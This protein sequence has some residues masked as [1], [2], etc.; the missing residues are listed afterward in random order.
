MTVTDI[1]I[2][3]EKKDRSES[4]GDL[5][6]TMSK[7][8]AKVEIGGYDWRMRLQTGL[9]GKE[10]QDVVLQL[11]QY[12][13]PAPFYV[14]TSF[15]IDTGRHDSQR[16][17]LCAHNGWQIRARDF[18]PTGTTFGRITCQL[19]IFHEKGKKS[20]REEEEPKTVNGIIGYGF[21]KFTGE[22]QAQISPSLWLGGRQWTL[23]LFKKFYNDGAY[24]NLSLALASYSV[25]PTQAVSAHFKLGGY[26]GNSEKTMTRHMPIVLEKFLSEDRFNAMLEAFPEPT[27]LVPVSCAISFLEN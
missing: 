27:D 25:A 15:T 12:P 9:N 19:I 10:Y 18:L 3:E 23:S 22:I 7:K 11:F 4:Q 24:L 8:E 14:R 16:T 6:I 21:G 1:N 20:D 17:L 5:S 13:S 26:K 2:I